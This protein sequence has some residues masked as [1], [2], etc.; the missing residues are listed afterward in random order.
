MFLKRLYLSIFLSLCFSP[1]CVLAQGNLDLLKK[2]DSLYQLPSPTEE[3]DRLAIKLYSEALA[4]TPNSEEVQ[5][6]LRGSERLGVLLSVYGENEAAAKS[7]RKGIQL[8]KAFKLPD[9]LVYSSHLFLGE[10]L[11]SLSKL[12]SS[13]YHL[14]EA[15]NLQKLIQEKT[16]PERL[17]NALGVYFFETGNY[18]QSI[19]YFSRAESALPSSLGDYGR[20][21][22]YSFLSNKASALYNLEKYDSAKKIYEDLLTWE[23]NP[24]Q[25]RINLANTHLEEGNPDQ[26]LDVLNQI[27]ET[28]EPLKFSHWNLLAKGYLLKKDLEAAELALD[29]TRDSLMTK[30]TRKK[31]L[32]RGIYHNLRGQL[33]EQ[34][35]E[36]Q[37]ALNSYQKAI[38]ELH[39]TF[40]NSDIFQNPEKSS[41]GMSSITLFEVLAS[42]AKIAWMLY[43]KEEDSKWFRL[44][45]STYLSAFD[46]A[47]Y[48]SFNFDNDEAR[49][50]LG[51]QVLK[52]YQIAIERIYNIALER[53]ELG[54]MEQAFVWAE[55]SKAGALRQSAYFERL[56]RRS[57]IPLAKLQEEENLQF[58]L[59]KNYQRQYLSNDPEELKKL[60]EEFVKLQVDLSR[61]REEF[62]SFLPDFE[63]ADVFSLAR[64]QDQLGRRKASL[65][66]FQTSS[67][68]FVFWVEPEF[69]DFKA[70]DIKEINFR[71]LE[72]WRKALQTPNLGR[73]Y[74][75]GAF[76][77]QFGKTLFDPWLVRMKSRNQLIVV[78]H[79]QFNSIPFE[80]LPIDGE[81]LIERIAVLYQFSAA[82][83]KSEP[84]KEWFSNAVL[85]FS[86]FEQKG[87]QGLSR[88][89]GSKEEIS[90]K[91]FTV[92]TDES[93]DLKTFLKEAPNYPYIHLATH[94]KAE[95]GDI[96]SSF[97]AFYP[98]LEEFR[99][100]SQELSYQALDS[101]EFVFL[102]ACETG[103]GQLSDSEGL[104]SLAR[105]FALAGADHLITSLWLTENQVAVYLSDAF[106]RHLQEGES[107]ASALRL[108]KLDL[109][110]DPKMSQFSH[111]GYWAN[112]VLIGQPEVVSF[113][114]KVKEVIGRIALVLFILAGI[115]WIIYRS[116][117]KE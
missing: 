24:N 96:N 10:L 1:I 67:K 83:V 48:I 57:G 55:Q 80:V 2:A 69:F 88:L 9:T 16:Q 77:S 27:S 76:I 74:D 87:F 54:L 73:K 47:N 110:N 7:Y 30:L 25:V 44:G 8:A 85:G 17:F 11:F 102:S 61:L 66:L 109:L 28:S 93:A 114:R 70:L 40:Q 4:E 19:S 32:Q 34:K 12:D 53:D 81:Y 5:L 31:D 18:S 45:L 82:L 51:D 21:A 60:Q 26:A 86:P 14:K 23:I 75:A 46:F 20:Y 58:L 98:G 105:S 94:A 15:E 36:Y 84:K 50:F 108:A 52:A 43:E 115:V 71:E 101:V 35:K 56:K 64:Y 97:I 78:P 38:I 41:L 104:I 95:P 112:Y 90:R 100:F 63:N 99:L 92:F 37:K 39:P 103:A 106:Y 89:P 117:K 65:S 62:K 68:L 59:S 113:E 6:F 22:R 13:I 49:I 107:Y 116:N 33:H 3:D 72:N 79:A 42:K 91:G 111:P 29:R